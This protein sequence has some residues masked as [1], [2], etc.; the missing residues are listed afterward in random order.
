MDRD[1]DP[2]FT[3]TLCHI[4]TDTLYFDFQ[5]NYTNPDSFLIAGSQ[6]V[7]DSTYILELS[8]LFSDPS[9]N[10][11]FVK[12][13][14]Q[15]VNNS[16]SWI[17]TGGAK[18][19]L[20]TANE[21][22]EKKELYGCHSAALMIAAILRAFNFPVVMIET[23]SV[24][25]A[26]KYKKGKTQN[27]IGH[28]MNEVYIESN[29]ILLDNKGDMALEYDPDLPYIYRGIPGVRHLF[30]FAKGKDTWDYYEKSN[31]DTHA[32]M[33]FFS[34]NIYCYTPYLYTNKYEWSH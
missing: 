7:L 34:D 33:I 21:L 20:V 15:W 1:Q 28:V 29:W 11:E 4:E 32:M 23:A 24:D 8:E 10:I 9:N 27:F 13:I 2:P 18:V 14:A 6:S 5:I 19:G 25:W 26:Y 22:Y 31:S 3:D 12:T 30:V 17:D 16:Y